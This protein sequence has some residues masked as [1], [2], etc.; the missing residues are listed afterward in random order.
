MFAKHPGFTFVVVLTL[1]LGIGVNTA[2]FSLID[3]L[4]LRMRRICRSV[5][6]RGQIRTLNQSLPSAIRESQ[7]RAFVFQASRTLSF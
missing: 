5:S 4:M 2:M 6:T 3:A 1:A 7:K